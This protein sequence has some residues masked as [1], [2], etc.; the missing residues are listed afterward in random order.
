VGDTQLAACWAVTT[1]DGRF[2]YL[3]NTG[4][5]TLSSYAV[6]AGGMLT[7]LNAAS[8]VTGSGTV[9]LDSAIT[10]NSEFLYVLDD[11]T[12]EPA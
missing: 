12:G 4:S 9:P 7:L 2:V 6:G 1:N 10:S 3:S 5:G 11:G 8:G